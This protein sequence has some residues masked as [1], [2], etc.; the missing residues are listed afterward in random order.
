MAFWC[1]CEVTHVFNGY[2]SYI[3]RQLLLL[4]PLII[5][6]IIIIMIIIPTTVITSAVDSVPQMLNLN[7]FL[8]LERALSLLMQRP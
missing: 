5:I 7:L 8:N 1:V 4:L 2:K 3:S 6:I